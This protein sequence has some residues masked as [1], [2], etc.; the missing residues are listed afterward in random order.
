LS[1]LP[2]EDFNRDAPFVETP[3]AVSHGGGGAADAWTIGIL[4][5]LLIAS[6][7]RKIW[8]HRNDKLIRIDSPSP[9]WG[10]R[11]DNRR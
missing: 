1:L 10:V 9:I 4:L 7:A 5:L 11:T 8:R 2:L 6:A 3:V